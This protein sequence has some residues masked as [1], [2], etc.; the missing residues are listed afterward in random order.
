MEWWSSG[1]G[2]VI[3]TEHLNNGQMI[4]GDPSMQGAVS[5]PCAVGLDPW[6]PA[7]D[8]LELEITLHQ[9][10]CGS[11]SESNLD[12]DLD[13]GH[14]DE[15]CMKQ[16]LGENRISVAAT[17]QL[18]QQQ[19]IQSAGGHGAST[20]CTS[21]GEQQQ[22]HQGHRNFSSQN[23]R[24]NINNILNQTNSN[25]RNSNSNSLGCLSSTA[26]SPVSS[27]GSSPLDGAP[28]LNG[29]FPCGT[30]NQQAAVYEQHQ[31]SNHGNPHGHNHHHHHH[32]NETDS[33]AV[34]Q[35]SGLAILPEGSWCQADAQLGGSSERVKTKSNN[36]IYSMF[37][38]TSNG[39]NSNNND[40]QTD[41]CF[42]TVVTSSPGANTSTKPISH[43]STG[44]SSLLNH[45][46][47]TIKINNS[48]SSSNNKYTNNNNN[49]DNS[50][51]H[52]ETTGPQL[53][54]RIRQQRG[55]ST[56]AEEQQQKSR[57]C[58]HITDFV[59]TEEEKRLL[60]KEGYTDF[61]LSCQMRPLSKN[62]ERILRKIRRKIRNKKSA[63]CSRQRKKEYVE[64]LERKYESITIEYERLKRMMSNMKEQ[65]RPTIE[66]Y[67]N[68]NDHEDYSLSPP[69]NSISSK[70]VDDQFRRH[71]QMLHSTMVSTTTGPVKLA[72]CG[73]A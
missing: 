69:P 28:P 7:S 9:Q 72:R 5:N 2:S 58:R 14:T 65:S 46:T 18:I 59:L 22:H 38:K 71:N 16:Q 27:I 68:E 31:F 34:D 52:K 73:P 57:R 19:I 48:N 43:Q 49:N 35:A 37:S 70:D 25:R 3:S 56:D 24:L 23:N 51:N 26:T 64:D 1:I 36:Q 50:C 4:A 13:R 40:H 6:L 41:Y 67:S 21:N 11:N 54:R 60:L 29:T 55:T 15:V 33:L 20:Q 47:S 8:E 30:R 61:P 42:T 66:T 12:Q 62:E 45:N 44:G 10:A 17:S 63:Q 39:T 53:A 32:Y